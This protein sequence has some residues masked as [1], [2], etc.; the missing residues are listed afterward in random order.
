MS[1]LSR[2]DKSIQKNVNVL[3]REVQPSMKSV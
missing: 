2:Y 3:D 1:D